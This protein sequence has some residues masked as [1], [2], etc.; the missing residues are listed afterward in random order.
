MDALGIERARW[1]GH[2]WG[3]FAGWH[4]MT[5]HGER[6]ERFMPVSIPHPWLPEGPPDPR[7]LARGWYQVVLAAPL[8]G[9]LAHGRIG[10]PGQILRK[11]RVAGEW[12][13][14]EI[15]F[16]QEL[17]RRPRYREASTQYY[18][19]FLVRELPLLVKGQF[20][21]RRL[22]VPTRLVAG[23]SD[24]LLRGMGDEYREHAD[25]MEIHY[26]EGA[27]HWLPEESPEAVLEHA[28]EFLP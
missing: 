27:G 1:V 9:R 23:R 15:D 18:R 17:L 28:L 26:I 20:R 24:A 11:A 13:D 5:E 22:T 19:A 3:A 25:E 2:D 12:S 16:Y 6:F 10:F 21:D 8:L 7:R 4:A 14:E